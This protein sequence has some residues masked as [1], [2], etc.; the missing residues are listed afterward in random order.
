MGGRDPRSLTLDAG[1]LI[2]VEGADRRVGALLRRA[3]ERGARVFVPAGAL[4]QVWRR[5][6]RQARLA[7]LLEDP[8]VSVETLDEEM[9]K[10]AG[11]L[12]GRRGADDVIDATVAL[13]G[14]RY[15]S[16][17]LTSDPEDLRRL[18]PGLEVVGV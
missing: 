9:A 4:A 8:A 17:V 5:G 2:A 1:A 15:S 10:A 12:C 7:L 11:E 16:V 18:D 13:T 14:R 3:F 6:P